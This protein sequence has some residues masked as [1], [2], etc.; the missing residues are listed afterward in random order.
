MI[1]GDKFESLV[2][3]LLNVYIFFLSTTNWNAGLSISAGLLTLIVGYIYFSKK[4]TIQWKEKNFLYAFGFFTAM[5][6]LASFLSGTKNGRTAI[7][8][9]SYSMP[10]F[11]FY[12][13]LQRKEQRIAKL[14]PGLLA[15]LWV[16][17]GYGIR[18]LFQHGLSQRVHGP[19]ASPN[20]YAMVLEVVIP[21]LIFEAIKYRRNHQVGR[22]ILSLVTVVVST[23]L[24]FTSFSRGGIIGFLIGGI[25]VFLVQKLV[26]REWCIP[27]IV[28]LF[29]V[30]IFILTGLF[31]KTAAF[32]NNR[33]YDGER[34]LLWTSAYH[35]WADHKVYGVGISTWNTVYRQ[36][37]ILPGAREPGLMLPHN[38]IADF[39]SATGTLGGIGY[40][41]FMGYTFYLL[42]KKRYDE[43]DNNYLLVMF[44][45]ATAFF[46]HGMVDNTMFSKYG[47][48]L[49]YA[50][51]G[52]TLASFAYKNNMIDG[53]KE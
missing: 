34:K 21:W 18:Q 20:T 33:S 36:K 53:D 15:G 17:N 14:W 29:C 48:R 12:F 47:L 50:L 31:F 37:Y 7:N 11:L 30:L 19:V 42:L 22:Y 25:G 13:L 10:M 16:L 51:W 41:V 9:F 45:I 23:M 24:L 43:P 28:G 46:I 39:F 8:L 4:S 40:L 52:I 49:Y 35:M 44:W 32:Y 26:Q 2:L 38:N 6:V 1:I 3:F 27:R 5:V